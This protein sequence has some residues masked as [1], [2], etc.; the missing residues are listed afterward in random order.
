MSTSMELQTTPG[1]NKVVELVLE[2]FSNPEIAL[3]IGVREQVIKNRLRGIYR[4]AGISDRG[5]RVRL[6]EVFSANHEK[7]PL[8]KMAP[9]ARQVAELVISGS[10]NREIGLQLGVTVQVVKNYVRIVFDAC[11]V[12]SR[13]ELAARFRCA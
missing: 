12:W 10:R 5:K 8:P 6:I 9:R 7:L 11:G 1:E 3:R 4:K 13:T 2:G